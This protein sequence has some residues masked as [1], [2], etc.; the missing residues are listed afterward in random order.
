MKKFIPLYAVA[1]SLSVA[2][3][4]AFADAFAPGYSS[5]W[6]N[7][8][9]LTSDIENQVNGASGF[10]LAFVDTGITLNNKELIG[11][12]S[13]LSTCVATG[14]CSSWVIDTNG[15][16]T[17]VASIAAGSTATGGLMSGV[18]PKATL[19]SIKIAQANG[20][21]YPSD[22][23]NGIVTA[24]QR[25]AQVINVSYG[26]FM[27]PSTSTS[28]AYYNYQLVSA[29]NA[30]A[31][32]GA[33]IVFA[34][35]NSSTTFLSN[36]NQAGFSDDALR[37]IVFVGSVNS[38][39]SLSWFSNKPG[40][41]TFKSTTG[42]STSLSSLWIM[43][44]GE[45]I[46]APAI[47]YGSTAYGY[48]TGTSM[49]A[50]I[51]AGALALLETKWPILATNGTATSVLFESA[52]DLGAAG[53]DT[54]YG[55]GLLN[56]AKAFEPI[57]T[58]STAQ[59]DGSLTPLT[60][61]SGG[62]LS[63]GSLGSMSALSSQLA[64]ATVFDSY[65]RNF[66]ADL[67]G[68]VVKKPANANAQLASVVQAPA[69]K[70]SASFLQDGSVYS[71]VESQ[72]PSQIMTESAKI[73]SPLA[74]LPQQTWIMAFSQSSGLAVETGQGFSPTAA[75]ADTLW[76][77]GSNAAEGLHEVNA[78]NALMSLT[79]GGRFVSLGNKLGANARYA[80][81]WSSTSLAQDAL[82]GSNWQTSKADALNAGVTWRMADFGEHSLWDAGMTV[83]YLGE[84]SGLLGSLYD[85]N[86]LVNLGDQ[87]HSLSVGLSSF[88]ALGASTGLT[89]DAA[90][91][92]TD[93]SKVAN[94]LVSSVSSMVSRSYGAA[95]TH[96]GL[97]GSDDH[98]SLSARRPLRVASG[99]ADLVTASVD[100]HGYPVIGATRVNMAPTGNQTDISLGY[101][102]PL[103]DGVDLSTSTAFSQDYGHVSGASNIQLSLGLKMKF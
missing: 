85:S 23:Y 1:L 67:S 53:T 83:G 15:H 94:G 35:G 61:T 2:A 90:M 43:A 18:A 68:L 25:S 3:S 74:A 103:A 55:R 21:A 34:G 5:S 9:N 89:F 101:G 59:A 14:N 16:G 65:Q 92:R 95:L 19:I 79:E 37:R 48:W 39:N 80:L 33:I 45:N 76:G 99:S 54:T 97:F 17:A 47:Q 8:I 86:G 75:F 30:A 98:I 49:S 88:F 100:E 62:V 44:P 71:L 36:L 87:H 91:V 81:S 20:G 64:N 58:L 56:V 57:G 50:P 42:A 12:V 40:S 29:I 93:G 13:T 63:G 11:R 22:L 24:A 60:T 31:A 52:T 72:G 46:V 28:Y 69:V 77:F 6:W 27:T 84:N 82:G 32:K 38:S 51:V 4:P 41:S 26:S 96:R 102:L 70:S 66:T 73:A 7:Q 10:K 78:S